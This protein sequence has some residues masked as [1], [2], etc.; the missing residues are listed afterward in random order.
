MNDKNEAAREQAR[1]ILKNGILDMSIARLIQMSN[2]GLKGNI[3]LS[4]RSI[5]IQNVFNRIGY[6]EE[7][8]TITFSTEE[9][10]SSYGA[11]SIVHKPVVYGSVSFFIGDIE[12]IS[13]CEDADNP[14]EW[15][16]I[17]IQMENGTTI[18]I[19]ILY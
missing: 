13:G 18:K 15:L 5:S 3:E 8:D 16:N 12:D 1:Q 2:Y 11:I 17:N 4:N 7:K 10:T 6:D 19:S 9:T 14:E